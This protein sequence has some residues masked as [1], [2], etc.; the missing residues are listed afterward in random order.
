M[1]HHSSSPLRSGILSGIIAMA[2]CSASYAAPLH[3]FENGSYVVPIVVPDPADQDTQR[4]ADLLTDTL[5]TITG[6]EPTV[7]TLQKD[8]PLPD[9]CIV[10]GPQLAS[11]AGAALPGDLKPDGLIV[12]REGDRLI[13]AGSPPRG[14]YYAVADFL[15]RELG[16]RWLSEERV[17]L[18]AREAIAIDVVNRREEPAFRFHRPL[19]LG[20][21][22]QAARLTPAP[23]SDGNVHSFHL[24]FINLVTYFAEHPD[25]YSWH[26]GTHRGVGSWFHKTGQIN[27][28]HPDVR[29]IVARKTA[30]GFKTYP[31]W[32]YRWISQEDC[33]G[34][35]EDHRTNAF[36]SRHGTVAASHVDFINAVARKVAKANP[37]KKLCTLAYLQTWQAPEDMRYEPNVRLYVCQPDGLWGRAISHAGRFGQD[38][39]RMLKRWADRSDETHTWWYYQFMIPK[40]HMSPD[41]AGLSADFRAFRDAGADGIFGECY[42]GVPKR[43]TGEYFTQLRGYLIAKLCWNPDLDAETLIRDFHL[44]YFGP[45]S[46]PAMLK[47]YQEAVKDQVTFDADAWSDE[48][49]D[50]LEQLAAKALEKAD[51]DFARREIRKSLRSVAVMKLMKKVGPWRVEEGRWT[52]G[53]AEPGVDELLKQVKALST[54]IDDEQNVDVDKIRYDQPAVTLSNDEIELTVVPSGGGAIARIID[55]TSGQDYA[56]M[57]LS[58]I[59]GM[60]VGGYQELAGFSFS[61]PGIR[62]AFKVVKQDA[63]S[64]TLSADVPNIQGRLERTISLVQGRPGFRVK[65][66]FVNTSK[67]ATSMGFRTHPMFRI[68]DAE[69]VY[70]AYRTRTGKNVAEPIQAWECLSA[71]WGPTGLWAMINP[72][73][74]RGLL[75]ESP[76]VHNGHFIWANP[77]RNTLACETFSERAEVE[78]GKKLEME[79]T[80]TILRDAKTWCRDQHMPVPFPGEDDADLPKADA[81]GRRSMLR[82]LSRGEKWVR[83]N[84]LMFTG[85]Y[86]RDLQN[87]SHF[88]PYHNLYPYALPTDRKESNI[89]FLESI[90]MPWIWLGESGPF[91]SGKNWRDDKLPDVTRK[92]EVGYLLDEDVLWWR[93]IPTGRV[94]SERVRVNRTRQARPDALTLLA[95][96]AWNRQYGCIRL[97][98]YARPDV[99][100]GEVYPFTHN[101][102]GNSLFGQLRWAREAGMRT[103][104]PW[105]NFIQTFGNSDPGKNKGHVRLPSESEQRLQ[106]FAALTWGYTGFL[107]YY[108]AL[109]DRYYEGTSVPLLVTKSGQPTEAYHVQKQ[110]IRETMN[111]GKGLSQLRHLDA[112][113]YNERQRLLRG[114]GVDIEAAPVTMGRFCDDTGDDSY[115][116]VTNIHAHG[117]KTAKE[118][119]RTIQLRI[120]PGRVI[121]ELDRTTGNIIR[122]VSTPESSDKPAGLEFTLPGGTGVLLKVDNGRGFAILDSTSS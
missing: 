11:R 57:T 25:Y 41:I 110:V 17:L 12:R 113:F 74:N 101:S 36:D 87:P 81:Q 2:S 1:H 18:P 60:L 67:K 16:C 90:K 9:A 116:M 15:E 104:R 62:N 22:E 55:R 20:V 95:F 43:Q 82:P 122:H 19:Q 53:Y 64:V 46:G 39:F 111:L 54:T 93:D 102:M 76:P 73:E 120:Q 69:D 45:Q 105:W 49:L 51:N 85:W 34:W 103:G 8:Q 14:T 30:E 100:V 92:G 119:T 56:G 50:R 118:L 48:K 94:A 115:F 91:L 117:K 78:P 23:A 6:I 47:F 3:L 84:G 42:S 71:G 63:T 72:K 79:Q 13:L 106:V 33:F 77:F 29:D 21:P 38:Y 97:A 40:F 88:K 10:L 112:G 80:F 121:F 24:Q 31:Q 4:A 107:D 68:G 86:G 59:G 35:S 37:D 83:K 98:D 75:W 108:Y 27:Y 114:L 89:P 58:R 44:H 109:S 66:R 26:F 5:K 99:V 52:N 70:F 96:H 7:M 32:D 28:H 65:S 61:S